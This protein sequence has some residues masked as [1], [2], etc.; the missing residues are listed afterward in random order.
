MRLEVG[1]NMMK[2]IA[3]RNA[4]K[5]FPTGDPKFAVMQAFPG[6]FSTQET[7]P[8]LMCDFFGPSVSK[9]LAKN[10]DDFEIGWH[11]HRGMDICTYLKEGVGRHGDS[12]GNRETYAT[13]VSAVYVYNTVSSLYFTSSLF[14]QGMQWVSVGSGI[15][16]AEGGGTPAGENTTGFQLWINVPSA[17]KM[18]DPAYGT[19][20]SEKLPCFKV[21]DGVK[22]TLLAGK[23]ANHEGPFI[24]KQPLEMIDFT[25]QP[26]STISHSV[27]THLNNCLLFVYDG[28]GSVG[29][30]KVSQHNVVHLDASLEAVRSIHLSTESASMGVMLFAGTRLNEPV[31][32]RGPFVMNTEAEIQRTLAEYRSGHFPPKRVSWDYKTLASFPADH[33]ARSE[34]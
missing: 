20:P 22:A 31:A 32:W 11:P 8:F 3:V 9:G 12:L 19:V 34:L 17:H 13:P 6:E 7:D 24:T 27:P 10:E 1:M 25:L 33:P 28:S 4:K 30:R 23:L 15:E 21:N 2:I 18:D 5:A 26:N 14:Y 16:H 29:D